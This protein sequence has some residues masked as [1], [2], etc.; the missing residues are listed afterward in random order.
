[1]KGS[2]IIDMFSEEPSF[3]IETI[4]L[5]SSIYKDSPEEE[6]TKIRRK[7]FTEHMWSV[8]LSGL[9]CLH[10]IAFAIT[11]TYASACIALC[12]ATWSVAVYHTVFFVQ[13][14]MRYRALVRIFQK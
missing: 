13:R 3:E 10:L 9:M 6:Q 4:N 7:L 12:V 11:F 5:L 8:S 1:M 2:V 14:L